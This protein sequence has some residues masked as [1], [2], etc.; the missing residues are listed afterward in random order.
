MVAKVLTP[1]SSGIAIGNASLPKEGPKAV[2][3]QANFG[4][5]PQ[6]AIDLQYIFAQTLMS[7]VQTVW[8][9]NSANVTEVS[10]FVSATQQTLNIP[11]NFQGYFPILSP[12][13]GQ[14][15]VS[16]SAGN[17]VVILINVPMSALGGWSPTSVPAP[18]FLFDING[19]LKTADQ[20]LAP[21]I[22]PVLGLLTRSTGGGGGA[23]NSTFMCD[24][25]WNDGNQHDL[26]TWTNTSFHFIMT[27]LRLVMHN[28]TTVGGGAFRRPRVYFDS[29]STPV[30]TVFET[31][32]FVDAVSVGHD[33]VIIEEYSLQ[34]PINTSA[35]FGEVQ[36][37][38]FSG[39]T[40][41]GWGI[42]IWG[43]LAPN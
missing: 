35:N 17:V 8:V 40:G 31:Q 12:T 37:Q 18:H 41:S 20:N 2:P 5:A 15:L 9:D 24:V 4:A 34:I 19:N 25:T 32:V 22:D 1:F 27:G 28:G 38:T 30:Q 7:M 13:Q 23:L 6:Y 16:G 36:D 10:I 43:D 29:G 14:M 26:F 11:A 42:Q 39:V 3:F 21:I 33:L